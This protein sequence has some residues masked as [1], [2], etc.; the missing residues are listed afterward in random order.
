MI[1]MASYLKRKNKKEDLVHCKFLDLFFYIE[2]FVKRNFQ[3]SRY[4]KFT[5]GVDKGD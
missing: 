4:S 5:R 3:R 1:I 2:F